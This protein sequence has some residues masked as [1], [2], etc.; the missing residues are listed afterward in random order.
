MISGM[1]LRPLHFPTSTPRGYRPVLGPGGRAGLLAAMALIAVTAPASAQ[2]PRPAAPAAARPGDWGTPLH[3]AAGTRFSPLDQVTPD[4]VGQLEEIWRF[5]GPV[6]GGWEGGPLVVN[7]VMYLHTPFPNRVVALDLTRPGTVLWTYQPPVGRAAPPTA[8]RGTGARGLAWHPRGIV[9]VPI[10]PGDLAALDARTGREIWRV[11]NA[12]SAVGGTLSGVPL[13]ADNVVLVGM[14]GS[15]YGVRGYL[16]AYQADNGRLLWR[17]HTT[18]PDDEVLAGAAAASHRALGQSTWPGEAWRQGGGSV[19]GW[20]TWDPVLKLVYH[21]TG[22]P[23][24]WNASPR[25]GDNKWTSSILARDLATGQLR[26]GFQTTTGDAWGYGAESENI[27]VDLAIGGQ[28]LP[29]LVHVGRNGFAYTL[30]RRTG[31]LIVVERAGPVNWVS[32]VD[33][34]TGVPTKAPRYLPGPTGTTRGICPATVGLKGSAPAAFS[35]ATG[36]L[37]APLVNLCMDATTSAPVL[38]AGLPYLG[39]SWRLLP[40]PGPSM[41][42]LI[43]WDPAVGAIRWEVGEPYPILGGVLTTASGLVFYA[44]TDGWLKAVDQT[45]GR[46]R[47][48]YRLP[49]GSVGSPMTYLGPDGRQYLAVLLGVGGWPSLANATAVRAPD[50][51]AEQPG[52]LLVLG[53]PRDGGN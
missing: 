11:R 2:R 20:L 22:A 16:T 24:P 46:E 31:R 34:A 41:G 44:T 27:L 29:A 40:G 53:L 1:P 25:P 51:N 28:P 19:D 50:W 21:G 23:A 6:P 13:V 43:A 52:M 12:N 14:A 37:Y 5:Q 26:W 10:L 7:D 8:A 49:A 18:G 15:E 30:D 38:T 33:P 36:L 48:R 42:R 9:Y 47:W 32:H 35:P 45:N 39:A 4:N 17:A 3:D